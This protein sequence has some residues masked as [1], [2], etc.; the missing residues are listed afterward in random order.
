LD[1]AFSGPLGQLLDKNYIKL[2]VTLDEP[3]L[4]W[5]T[6]AQFYVDLKVLLLPSAISKPLTK[7]RSSH[8][9]L[10]IEDEAILNDLQQTKEAFM[11]LFESLG[12]QMKTPTLVKRTVMPIVGNQKS[13]KKKN[14]LAKEEENEEESKNQQQQHQPQN[15]ENELFK[16]LHS[17]ED[18]FSCE[19]LEPSQVISLLSL[20]VDQEE[21]KVLTWMLL[22]EGSNENQREVLYRKARILHPLWEEYILQEGSLL[23]FN[24]FTGQLSV[25]TPKNTFDCSGGIIGNME[26]GLK[27][28]MVAGLVNANRFDR[29]T[30][31]GYDPMLVRKKNLIMIH[32]RSTVSN[33]MK[34][35]LLPAGTLLIV[36]VNSL[37]FWESALSRLRNQDKAMKVLV[38]YGQKRAQEGKDLGVGAYDVVL[39]TYGIISGEFSG[40]G[41]KDLYNYEWFRVIL[42]EA[43]YIKGKRIQTVKAIEDLNMLN[44]WCLSG[45]NEKSK[46]ED[47]YNM[48]NFLKIE[49]WNC[50]TWWNAH[51]GKPILE[52]GEAESFEIVKTILS[53]LALILNNGGGEF[54]QRMA[55]L[56]QIMEAE[57]SYKVEMVELAKEERDYY[58]CLYKKSKTEFDKLLGLD[59]LAENYTQAYALA[60]RIR[61]ACDHLFLI[62]SKFE[63]RDSDC[64]AGE[65]VD[66]LGAHYED[67]DENASKRESIGDELSI[68]DPSSLR[69]KFHDHFEIVMDE[70]TRVEHVLAIQKPHAI[71]NREMVQETV[72]RLNQGDV[73]HCPICLNDLENAVVTICGH[74]LCNVCEKKSIED[75]SM[76]PVCSTI[77]T[78]KDCLNITR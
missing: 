54:G 30:T 65:I 58:G 51:I 19:E 31:G 28:Q 27:V 46:L 60:M 45:I 69:D 32:G 76:C 62:Y 9:D 75:R 2:E 48:V 10:S 34:G 61:Y 66:F 5:S 63:I 77:L 6:F 20:P 25:E 23:Y 26:R 18:Y 22:R 64:L 42:D 14:S 78:R 38:Y 21:A 73:V 36:P 59:A 74:I 41:K 17:S 67:N 12:L 44:R 1:T 68:K 13:L 4:S 55:R 33:I 70:N 49:P 71:V 57:K 24:P 72:E 56:S 8:E 53:P 43:H 11:W 40:E 39:T 37:Y 16:Y 47:L 15:V 29:E 3:P 7:V 35:P 52:K 50:L